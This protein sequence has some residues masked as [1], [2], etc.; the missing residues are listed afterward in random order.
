LNWADSEYCL[1]RG[2]AGIRAIPEISCPQFIWHVLRCNKQELERRGTGSTF[3]QISRNVIEEL[4]FPLPSYS[5]QKRIAAILDKAEAVQHRREKT[6]E[7]TDSFL[8][9]VF[10]EMF[11]DPVTNPK[12]WD[13]RP[14]SE[15][16]TKITD[17]VHFRPT[18]TENGIPFISV[19]DITTGKLCFEN[20]KFVSKE[21]HEKFCKR[22]KPEYLDILY[23]KVGATYGRP[24]LVDVQREFSLYVSV[25]LI[26]LRRD[27]IDP[28]FLNEVLANPAI[29]YQADRSIKGAGV[30][31]LHLIEIKNFLVPVPPLNIQ[32]EFL[33][34]VTKLHQISERQQRALNSQQSLFASVSSM[35]FG[36][37]IASTVNKKSDKA[38]KIGEDNALQL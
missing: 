7:L 33:K 28:H 3:R 18:Y 21:D 14:L 10:L 25:A 8:R 12:G 35:L 24:A 17:G 30:P 36:Q 11:G 38:S 1:G 27:I 20:T 32:Q 4:K 6:I 37:K 22:C 13:V 9:S 26:K 23:T 29:K 31:D 16:T 2:V 19:K 34:R 15:V 5:E